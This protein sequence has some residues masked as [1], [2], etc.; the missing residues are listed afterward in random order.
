MKYTG[1]NKYADI[2]IKIAFGSNSRG[3]KF[4]NEDVGK[5]TMKEC[6]ASL[7]KE[8]KDVGKMVWVD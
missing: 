5:F 2:L 7:K 3:N 1:D 4:I 6:L 8:S